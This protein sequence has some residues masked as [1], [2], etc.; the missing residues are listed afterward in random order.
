MIVW[1]IA[2]I[3]LCMFVGLVG[4]NQPIGFLGYSILSFLLSPI[5]G[6]VVLLLLSLYAQAAVKKAQREQ[7]MLQE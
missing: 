5:T 3:F 4:R 7:Q 2:Y 1:F 6:L